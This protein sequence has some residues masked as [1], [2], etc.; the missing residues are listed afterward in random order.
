MPR[1]DTRTPARKVWKDKQARFNT[2]LAHPVGMG[3]RIVYASRIPPR[4]LEA[5]RLGCLEAKRRREA[6][7]VAKRG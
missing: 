6:K 7:R 2:P 4:P 1:R 5:W 3:G